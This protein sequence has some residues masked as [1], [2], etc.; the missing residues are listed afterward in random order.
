MDKANSPLEQAKLVSIFVQGSL[1][2]K[3]AK[4]LS[5]KSD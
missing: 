5:G 2:G 3:A 4:F 1:Y